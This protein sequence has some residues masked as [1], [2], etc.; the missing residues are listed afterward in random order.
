MTLTTAPC[1]P[2]DEKLRLKICG[3]CHPDQGRAIAEIGATAIGFICVSTSPRYVT[4]DRIQSIIAKLPN[5]IDCVGV[6]ADATPAEIEYVIQ[7]AAL[8]ALQLHGQ[9]SPEFCQALRQAYPQLEIIKA[10]RVRSPQTLQQAS[11]YQ[12]AVDGILLD[13]YHPQQLGGSGQCF[14]WHWL[15]HWAFPRPW[16]LAGG[17]TPDNIQ[18]ALEQV[19]PPGVDLSSGVERSPGD[20]DLTKVERLFAAIRSW[21]ETSE[22]KVKIS[23]LE[24]VR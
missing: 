4:P 14:D 10:L 9:E 16:L 19:K 17:L 15:K 3:I 1:N 20:K 13:A 2:D 12:D 21:Q 5:K 24:N 22:C 11:A 23:K 6:F 18:K 7:Q 8:T